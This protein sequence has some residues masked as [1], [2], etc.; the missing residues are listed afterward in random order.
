[1]NK[2]DMD[3]QASLINLSL[4]EQKLAELFRLGVL[5]AADLNCSDTHSRDAIARLC[6]QTCV[7]GLCAQC[8]HQDQCQKSR[9]TINFMATNL[10]S[11]AHH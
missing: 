8:P 7:E 1:M 11:I 9:H 5:C 2:Q 4:S 3:R 10:I 6:L